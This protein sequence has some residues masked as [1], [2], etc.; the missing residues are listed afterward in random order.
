MW[1][2]NIKNIISLFMMIFNCMFEGI[3]ILIFSVILLDILQMEVNMGLK[4]FGVLCDLLKRTLNFIIYML[5][6]VA[7][8]L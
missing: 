3:I 5:A 1:A 7:D 2:I 8:G 4:L 6:I